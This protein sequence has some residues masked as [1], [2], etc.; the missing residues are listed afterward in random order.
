MTGGIA[1]VLLARAVSSPLRRMRAA[2]HEITLGHTDVTVTVDD[3]TEIGL[4]QA[5]VN[6]MVRDLRERRRMQDLFGRHVGSEVAEHALR[7]GASLSG[8]VREVTAL[9]VDVVDSTALAS[10]IAPGDVVDKLNR[11]F[12]AV[13]AAADANGGL[14]NKFAGD[15]ALCVFGAPAPLREPQLAALRAAR[16]IRDTVR[17]AGELDLGV[18]VACGEAFAGQLGSSQRFEY[19]VIGDPVNEASRLTEHAKQRPGRILASAAVIDGAPE[20]ERRCWRFHTDIALRGRGHTT[21]TWVDD[22]V[23]VALGGEPTYGSGVS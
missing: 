20:E 11:F 14:V 23:V 21:A 9:F 5:A 18:G 19:T 12:S 15:A 1:T 22:S 7:V 8:D 6:G 13:V 10:T 2:V 16:Q 17:D 4:L 3:S